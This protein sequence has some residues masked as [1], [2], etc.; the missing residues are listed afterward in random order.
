MTISL[1]VIICGVIGIG[2][3]LFFARLRVKISPK[4]DGFSRWTL[5]TLST[6]VL[7]SFLYQLS[8]LLVYFSDQLRTFPKLWGDIYWV[9]AGL[10]GLLFGFI[11]L[12]GPKFVAVIAMLQII[13]GLG[14]LGLLA[15]A[16]G[17]TSM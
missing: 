14:L 16:I 15:L 10:C 9:S 11:G 2:I 17:I 3:V 7:L 8:F 12:N 4:L 5:H 1:M 6:L 13:L